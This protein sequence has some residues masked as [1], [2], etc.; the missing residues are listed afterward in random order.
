MINEK[1]M[2]KQ[3]NNPKP[4]IFKIVTQ[5]DY[6]V[7]KRRNSNNQQIYEKQNKTKKLH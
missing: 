7:P 4:S 5:Y 2:E 6:T 3:K 1:N